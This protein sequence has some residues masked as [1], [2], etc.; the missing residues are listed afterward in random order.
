PSLN[1]GS[2][3]LMPTSMPHSG[4]EYN[5]QVLGELDMLLNQIPEVEV[6]VGKAGRVES[7]LD[8]APISM[9]ENIITYRPEFILDGDGRRIRFKVD[10]KNRFVTVSGDS[11]T[12]DEA[13]RQRI[14]IADLVKD[15]DGKFFRNW[16]TQ[17]KS[18]DDIWNE[19]VKVTKIPGITSAPKLQ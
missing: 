8:P 14:T 9:F 17:I 18:P 12:N 16:R 11:V 4:V 2:Y 3:L 15:S 6:V 13:L 10:N 7:A 19:I 1:E 5:R